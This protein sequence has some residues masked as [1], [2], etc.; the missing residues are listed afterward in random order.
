[1]ERGYN[2]SVLLSKHLSAHTGIPYKPLLK[3]VKRT[4]QQ[5]K[6]SKSDRLKNV[7]DAFIAKQTQ[8]TVLL[9]DDVITSGATSQACIEALHRAG[10]DNVKLA[11]IAMGARGR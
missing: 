11:A 4:Q 1:L 5:A 8:G 10:A 3:R 2:Q 7:Q 9:V 6:L